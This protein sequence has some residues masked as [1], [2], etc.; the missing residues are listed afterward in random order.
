MNLIELGTLARS[1]RIELGLSQTQ[2]ASLS[3]L[4][5]TTI[6]LLENGT[7]NDLGIG[8]AS[9]LM[10]LLG[11]E[12]H[13]QK[14]S[15]KKKNSLLMA[16]RSASV[17]YKESLSPKQLS[18]A[19]ISGLIPKNRAPHIATLLDEVPMS[20]IVSAVEEASINGS[21]APKKIWSQIG[22]AHV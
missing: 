5:R 6:N 17:S 9:Q 14:F 3:G 22:R 7:L 13:A 19:M 2:V 1:R 12:F 18:H 4:S 21:C 16:S 15:S 8:K 10:D 20:V 11:I